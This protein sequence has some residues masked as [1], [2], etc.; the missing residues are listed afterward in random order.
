MEKAEG[1]LTEKKVESVLPV[2]FDGTFRFT[3]FTDTDFVA[4]WDNVAYTFPAQRTTPIIIPD[5]TPLEIQSIRKKFAKELAIQCFYGTAKFK[6]MDDR[7]HGERPALYTDN[8]LAPFVQR[9]LEA[10][11]VG[12]V[13]SKVLPRDDE[14]RYRKDED[15]EPIS[16]PVDVKSK[17]SLVKESGVPIEN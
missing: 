15:G 5:R 11:P 8:D 16:K 6:D 3:N 9:C 14:S 13:K 1:S 10:L 7:K 4:K 2:D 17:R 12:Q